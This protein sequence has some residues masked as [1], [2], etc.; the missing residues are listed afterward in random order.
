MTKKFEEHSPP[1]SRPHFLSM[2]EVGVW[3]ATS[4]LLRLCKAVAASFAGS[5]VEKVPKELTLAQN[6]RHPLSNPTRASYARV[7]WTP[8]NRDSS[9]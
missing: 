1:Q 6:W 9:L 8:Y 5:A 4:A 3:R 2:I 7:N